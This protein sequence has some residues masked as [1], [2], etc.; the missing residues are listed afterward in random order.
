MG[1]FTAE[2]DPRR[3]YEVDQWLAAWLASS[4][5][6]ATYLAHQV[7]KATGHQLGFTAAEFR[8]VV[9]WAAAAMARDSSAVRPDWAFRADP[10]RSMT[11]HGAA[12]VDGLMVYLGGLADSHRPLTWSLNRDQGSHRYLDP[13]LEPDGPTIDHLPAVM[14]QLSA[15]HAGWN[16]IE[17]ILGWFDSPGA[18]SYQD[19][20]TP[21]AVR[22]ALI[23]KGGMWRRAVVPRELPSTRA[24]AVLSPDSRTPDGDRD[25]GDVVTDVGRGP[26]PGERSD[27]T[28]HAIAVMGA[29]EI[30]QAALLR[31]VRA[32]DAAPGIERVMFRSQR[33]IDIWAPGL[34]MVE[35]LMGVR[36]AARAELP[37]REGDG[38]LT[39][40][41][42]RALHLRAPFLA[43]LEQARDLAV[44]TIDLHG[45]DAQITVQTPWLDGFSFSVVFGPRIVERLEQPAMEA[46]ASAVGN[47]PG[48]DRVLWEEA[49]AFHLH[50]APTRAG[51]GEED[52]A[53]LAAA[54]VAQAQKIADAVAAAL[55]DVG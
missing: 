55:A 8:P 38:P 40:D 5:K 32:C 14:A 1:F 42:L 24:S 34:L 19:F 20:D 18:L 47:L 25:Y 15:G 22:S 45:W 43:R 10:G 16:Q 44:A 27:A 46:I 17:Q 13:V 49:H 28:H 37:E 31:L 9:D 36:A 2:D 35:V 53:A 12:L 39:G 30:N 51:G 50:I 33:L 23:P 48:V 11:M 26:A 6:S 3:F 29:G 7:R 41:E 52:A 4:P 21:P 54:Q